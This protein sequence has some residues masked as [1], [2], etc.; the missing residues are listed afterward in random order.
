VR[1]NS[2]SG[3]GSS[4]RLHQ[5][6]MDWIRK[7]M[8][9]SAV[10]TAVIAIYLA[11][12]FFAGGIPSWDT[13]DH[14]SRLRIL[15][16]VQA[17]VAAL[18]V[19]S[20]VL[21]VTLCILY[22]DEESLGYSLIALAV[23]LYYG[24]P[25]LLEFTAP[26]VLRSWTEGGNT[27]AALTF[28][29]MRFLGLMMAAPGAILSLRDIYL[30]IVD[31]TR[32]K[33]DRFSA[34][35]Y[36]GST[37]EEEPVHPAL[38]GMLSRCWQLPFCREFVRQRCPIFHART[39]CWRQRV[40]CMCE[41]SVIRHAMDAIMQDA[42]LD[43]T[44]NSAV[45]FAATVPDERRIDLDGSAGAAARKQAKELPARPA[46]PPVRRRDVKIP[47]NPNLS[48]FAKRERCRNCVIYNEHQ[49]L[50]YQFLGP[51]AVVV[52][53]ALAYWK[54][55]SIS[56][57]L[58]SGLH[59]VDALMSRF[60]MDPNSRNLGLA[61]SITGTSVVAEYAIIT[62]LVVIGTT[63]VLRFLEYCVFKLKV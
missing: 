7:L 13:I 39:K 8:Q 42:V 19:A 6:L 12:G 52:V 46:A 55:A 28:H 1:I 37:V 57:G 18:N 62:C 51:L 20:A 40:G 27:A 30:R 15:S 29:Q 10:A 44:E 38:I 33:R 5:T 63:M 35:E 23:L 2:R 54:L 56:V 43:R 24:V 4:A 45:D 36:G 16:N 9:L 14:A 11:Y 21:L 32:R 61:S 53:P 60:S 22:Y 17:A 48:A 59:H 41:E 25:Y 26:D 49:R 3:R 50:K 31:G 34:M 58:Q 47:H